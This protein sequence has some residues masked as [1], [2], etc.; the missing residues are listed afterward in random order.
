[1]ASQTDLDKGGT[2]RQLSKRYLGPSVG[3]IT[4]PATAAS[5]LPITAAGTYTV[6]LSTTLVTVNVN[7]AVTLNL[8]RARTPT[9]G[10]QAVPGP[11]AQN[12]IT[13]VDIGGFAG[14]Q[15]VTIN[16]AAGETIMGL[17]SIQLAVNYGGYTLKPLNAMAGWESISP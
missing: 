11:F 16:P 2:N 8:P 15:P 17:A 10:P 14:S 9:Q 6:E 7:G 13:I 3:W 12:P 4:T 1:M 5:V